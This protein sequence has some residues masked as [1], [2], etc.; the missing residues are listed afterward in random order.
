MIATNT[1][2]VV[3]YAEIVKDIA[4]VVIIADAAKVISVSE[5]IIVN[6]NPFIYII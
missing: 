4:V 1:I 2:I 5:K 3:A 6:V